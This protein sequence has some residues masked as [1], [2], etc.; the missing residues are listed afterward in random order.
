MNPR[1][2][3]SPAV[4]AP[5]RLAL[6]E[7]GFRP[8]FLLGAAFA[9]AAVPCWLLAL[10]GGL[11]PGGAFGAMHWHAHEMLFGFSGAI[12]AGF[13]LTAVSNW[14]GRE[15]A[16]GWPLAALAALWAL[17]RGALFWAD[18][19]PK[20]LP[21]ALDLAFL[22]V[23]A[24][25]CALP[26][27]GARNQ[28]N[29]GFVGMLLS[30]SIANGL[31]HWAALHGDGLALRSAHHAALNLIVLMMVVM[32][33]RVVPM[34]TRNATKLEWVRGI[35]LLERCSIAAVLLLT[36]A[37]LWPGAERASTVLAIIA[38]LLLLARMRFWGTAHT[39]SQPLLW[40]L[41]VGTLWLPVGLLL[42]AAASLTPLVPVASSLHALT[43][44]AIGSLTLGMMARVSLGHTGRLLRAAPAMNVGLGCLCAAAVLRVLAP[45]LPGAQYFAALTLAGLVWSSAFALFL[46]SYWT[47][48]LS[49][50]AD[51]R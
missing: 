18:R 32:T 25:I 12:I 16:T 38:A 37:E 14:T 51:A 27:L 10:R 15:T 43:V 2:L 47:I 33:G 42:R 23:L 7:K 5:P 48:L 26:L 24:L 21:A 49:P 8:F 9:L 19:L 41:H 31:S 50:R 17:G 1:S 28:R 22:P 3:L 13:L 46:L 6:F 36:I 34:F 11:Q 20:F 40:I 4:A 45:F 44:G 29:Y 39:F 30:L 35:T